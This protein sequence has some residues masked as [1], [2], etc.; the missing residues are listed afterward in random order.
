MSERESHK[1]EVLSIAVS[2]DG[3]FVATGGQDKTVRIWDAQRGNTIVVLE[4]NPG[5]VR[6]VAFSADGTWLAAASKGV[7]LWD[8]AKGAQ[9]RSVWGAGPPVASLAISCDG[10][11]LVAGDDDGQIKIWDVGAGREARRLQ[12]H[13]DRVCAL[14]V[15]ADGQ[16]LVSGSADKRC[17]LWDVP[18]GKAVG[19]FETGDVAVLAAAATANGKTVAAAVK[20][21]VAVWDVATKSKRTLLSTSAT[22]LAF[23]SGETLYMLTAGGTGG[24]VAVHSVKDDKPAPGLGVNGASLARAALGGGGKTL[25]GSDGYRIFVWDLK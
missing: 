17:K 12:G 3:K 4:K 5:E 18:S 7:V 24:A 25:A 10:K 11:Y 23:D 21:G 14:A 9:T 13:T 20:Q 22:W 6:A 19:E 8:P 1:G 16:M 15:S 2:A